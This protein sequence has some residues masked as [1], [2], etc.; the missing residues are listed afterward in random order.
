LKE[1]LCKSRIKFDVSSLIV[2][3]EFTGRL[4]L[5]F[6]PAVAEKSNNIVMKAVSN[7][8]KKLFKAK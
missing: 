4:H 1:S 3:K 8:L 2:K 6:L 7:I 5:K